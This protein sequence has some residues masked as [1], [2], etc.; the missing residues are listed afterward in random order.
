MALLNEPHEVHTGPLLE[1]VQV[2]LDGIP[3]FWYANKYLNYFLNRNQGGHL[4]D[5][6]LH[7]EQ[8]YLVHFNSHR[9]QGE[10]Y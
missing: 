7:V 2:P 8:L 10:G 3:S 4:H 5:L 9:S 6:L 1:L